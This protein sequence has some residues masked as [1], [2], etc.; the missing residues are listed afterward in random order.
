METVEIQCTVAS[1]KTLADGGIRI[2]IDIGENNIEPAAKLMACKQA[3]VVL[4]ANLTPIEVKEING[5]TKPISRRK[6]KRRVG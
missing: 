1:V 2:S 4:Q 6:A 3:G 5:G